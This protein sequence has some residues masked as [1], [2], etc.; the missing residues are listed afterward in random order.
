MNNEFIP[1]KLT[2]ILIELGY[3]YDAI[4]YHR[5][6]M[7]RKPIISKSTAVRLGSVHTYLIYPS[8][9][10]QQAFRFFREEHNLYH[11]I[12]LHDPDF[13]ETWRFK[14]D[15][16]GGEIAYIHKSNSGTYFKTYEDA[17]LACVKKLIEIVNKKS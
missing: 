15:Y 16:I 10:F 12:N 5:A 6:D 1:Y 3:N 14:I 7:K 13:D 17:E 11:K 4:C 9:L 8:I 2:R